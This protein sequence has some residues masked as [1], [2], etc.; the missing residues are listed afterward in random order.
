MLRKVGGVPLLI[1]ALKWRAAK[2]RALPGG[3]ARGSPTRLKSASTFRGRTRPAG[4]AM[5]WSQLDA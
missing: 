1:T 2:V 3:A 5:I 4:T